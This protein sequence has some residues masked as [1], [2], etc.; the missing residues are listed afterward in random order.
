MKVS[1]QEQADP[2]PVLPWPGSPSAVSA[3]RGVCPVWGEPA[4]AGA[5]EAFGRRRRRCAH[6]GSGCGAQA[7]DLPCGGLG[8]GGVTGNRSV[9]YPMVPSA[10]T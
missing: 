5:E 4:A 2:R 3:A 9:P 6:F 1:F 8:N 7:E 10:S